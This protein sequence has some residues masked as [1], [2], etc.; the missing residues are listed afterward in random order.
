MFDPRELEIPIVGAPLAGGPSTPELTAAVS[1]AG[2]LGFVAAGY[3]SAQDTRSA[4]REVARRTDRP[5]GLNLFA[6]GGAAADDEVVERY[7][8]ELAPET[9][10]YGVTLGAPRHDDDGW[11]EKLAVAA[12]ERPA[13][14]S[15]TFGCPSS[16]EVAVLHDAGIA[17][18][19]T[20]TTPAEAAEA[21]SAEA[22]AL[23]AQGAEAGGHRGSFDDGATGE[24]G[25][26]ALLQLVRAITTLPLIASGG[27]ATGAGIAA[28]L[29]AGASAVQ[30]GSAFLLATEAGTSDA[31]RQALAAGGSTALTRAFTGRTARGLRNRFM[32]D[33]GDAAPSAYPEIHHLT[34]P[35]RAEAR[36]RGD[37]GALNLWAGQASS[38]ARAAPAG[39]IVREL[40]D[41]A[42]AALRDAQRRHAAQ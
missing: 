26:L 3:R 10:R 38:L 27:I 7:A 4:L 9:E 35:L 42:R 6:A 39:D 15:T 37:A 18:W 41:E 23:V 33:H 30:L 36:R 11:A 24:I 34:A 29:A 14:V 31:H 22:D 19:V 28:A 20:V 17:I 16:A 12:E 21:A 2:G 32:D 13:V 5:F 40:A 8:R 25:L 1:A